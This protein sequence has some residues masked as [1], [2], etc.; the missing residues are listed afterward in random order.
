MRRVARRRLQRSL[1]QGGNLIV[2]DRA[3]AARSRFVKQAIT[4]ILQKSAAPLANG[5]V[6]DAEFG[7]HGLVWQAICTPQ[8]RAAPLR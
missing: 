7:S 8:D 6:M 5:V 2:A 3:R 1:D 4:A